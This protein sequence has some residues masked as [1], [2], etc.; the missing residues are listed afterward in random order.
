MGIWWPYP[1]S[2]T[3]LHKSGV[4]SELSAPPAVYLPLKMIE[5]AFIVSS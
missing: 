2:N 1:L 3:I 5:P 4:L